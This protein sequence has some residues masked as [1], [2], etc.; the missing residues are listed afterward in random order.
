MR[1]IK[2]GIILLLLLILSLAVMPVKTL[3]THASVFASIQGYIID[4]SYEAY[5]NRIMTT[6]K[7][8]AVEVNTQV[9][10]S[11]D[12]SANNGSYKLTDLLPG[13]YQLSASAGLY[14]STGYAYANTTLPYKITVKEG[15][16]LTNINIPLNRGCK[17]EGFIRYIS[18]QSMQPIRAIAD[19]PWLKASITWLNYTVEAYDLKGNLKGQYNSS[20][21]A[22]SP[23]DAT[24]SPFTIVGTQYAGLEPG[25]YHLKPWVFGYVNK[26]STVVTATTLGG[27]VS[28]IYINLYSGGIISGTI[29]FA[30]PMGS[31]ETPKA[32]SDAS[33]AI[34][35]GNVGINVFDSSGALKGVCIHNWI[36]STLYA[37]QET[38]AVGSDSYYLLNYDSAEKLGTNLSVDM[39]SAGRKL[40]GHFV[41]PLTGISSM[42]AGTWTIYYRAWYS[43]G[44][45]AHCDVNIRILK[46]DGNVRTGIGQFVVQNVANSGTLTTTPQTLSG[47]Y[48]WADYTV[49][50]QTDYLEIDYY[51]EVTSPQASAYAYL[52]IDDH[53]LAPSDQTR[54]TNIN[55]AADDLTTTLRFYVLGFSEYYNKTYTGRAYK[56]YGLA[57]GVYM[58]RVY[59]RGYLQKT[60]DTVAISQGGNS[61]I[62]VTMTRGGAIIA[63]AHSM[64]GDSHIQW[65]YSGSNIK[66][67][68]HGTFWLYLGV[69]Q[70]SIADRFVMRFSGLDYPISALQSG[71]L[72]VGLFDG[73]YK[74]TVYTYGY[75]QP[76]DVY[77]TITQGSK[78]EVLLLAQL[79]CQVSGRLIF[80]TQNVITPL[81]E[82]VTFDVGVFDLN[83]TLKGDG[84]INS[85]TRG[86][87]D[88][89]FWRGGMGDYGLDA[90][91]YQVKLID[92]HGATVK[93]MQV[94]NVTVTLAKLGDTVER[95][96]IVHEMGRV[97]GIIKEYGALG[98]LVP[99][100]G[101]K[102]N[103][104]NGGGAIETISGDDGN[105][106]LNLPV[107]RTNVNQPIK[108]KVTFSRYYFINQT[109]P[110]ETYSGAK[111][112]LNV[113]LVV[114]PEFPTG[115]TIIL[116]LA[117]GL[118]S[119]LLYRIK[120]GAKQAKIF[121]KKEPI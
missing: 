70:D 29:T 102:V 94:A 23:Q 41:Y 115:P 55:S 101:V 61:T 48:N 92:C 36:P 72:P 111:T 49:V 9:S 15:T 105:Y 114:V 30:N 40:W 112:L 90:G 66:I 77:A 35:G 10:T 32:A 64:S 44:G 43:A 73:T 65:R 8:Y 117:Y 67:Y 108:Y 16:N 89:P 6:G 83:G 106:S 71:Y 18:S 20:F 91:T 38:T 19:N 37:H 93:Y 45:T 85:A 25:T 7:V 103:T 98:N 86:A 31:P 95:Q 96:I 42:P 59:L 74:L 11:V 121:R 88:A 109:I 68:V 99:L 14:P 47:T 110:V 87:S 100:S 118:I 76:V 82:D 62:R 116:T 34:F 3:T 113:V 84:G 97:Y 22:L 69:M 107:D 52:R 13:T 60:T 50:D 78:I 54:A 26:T 104:T 51:C 120:K 5:A 1:K 4:K 79:G 58:V 63:T 75:V 81:S 39:S 57:D 17:I 33:G 21:Q 53:L 80:K 46:S 27:T 119:L 28:S 12:V 2:T 56:D 24:T